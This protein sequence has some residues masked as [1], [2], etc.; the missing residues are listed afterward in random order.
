M[1]DTN[2]KYA[3]EWLVIS[4]F[5]D[6]SRKLS[7]LLRYISL[8]LCHYIIKNSKLCFLI[9]NVNFNL[10]ININNN[11]KKSYLSYN[12]NYI[13]LIRYIN[14]NSRNNIKIQLNSFLKNFA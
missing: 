13:Y 4:T 7:H 11:I 1:R 12:S 8:W 2:D 5:R 6:C 10:S 3:C 14:N 9:V